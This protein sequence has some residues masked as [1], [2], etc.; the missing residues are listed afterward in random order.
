MR[1]GHLESRTGSG[2]GRGAKSPREDA[3]ARKVVV[4]R[5]EQEGDREGESLIMIALS[6]SDPHFE[7]QTLTTF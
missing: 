2:N 7:L 6:V 3:K 5:A 1:N 4:S